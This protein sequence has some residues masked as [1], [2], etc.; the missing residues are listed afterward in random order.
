MLMHFFEIAGG[1]HEGLWSGEMVNLVCSSAS[2]S[3]ACLALSLGG[4]VLV[5]MAQP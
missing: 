5:S 1:F 4:L 3:G 2:Q